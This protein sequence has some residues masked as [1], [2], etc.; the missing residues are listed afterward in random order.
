MSSSGKIKKLF[1]GSNVDVHS[2]F[3]ERILNAALSE[4]GES[5]KGILSPAEPVLLSTIIKSPIIKLATAALIIIAAVLAISLWERPASAAYAVEQTIEAMAKV[6]TIHCSMNF[7]TD[8][9]FELWIEVDPQTGEFN[10]IILDSPKLTKVS[11]LDGT[12][13]YYKN[14][15]EFVYLEDNIYFVSEIIFGPLINDMVDW[16]SSNNNY[17]MNIIEGENSV[18]S[19]TLEKEESTIEWKIDSETKLPISMSRI[20]KS[21]NMISK[22]DLEPLQIELSLNDF[23]YNV[24]LPAEYSNFQ[25]PEEIKDKKK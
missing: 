6:N 7:F 16:T 18:I 24:P 3:D 14:K 25:I 20:T 15:D 9:Q 12:Y 8:D 10:K 5:G 17:K 23:S 19:A 1:A 4:L 21:M 13:K 2:K 22:E 11:T